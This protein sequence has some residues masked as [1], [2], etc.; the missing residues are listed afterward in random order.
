MRI[1]TKAIT[2]TKSA[3]SRVF[4]SNHEVVK[5]G[6]DGRMIINVPFTQAVKLHSIKIV[7]SGDEAPKTIRTYVNRPHTLSF[8]EADSIEG[9]E[10]ITLTEKDYEPNAITPLRFV[11]YQ[12]VQSLTV[13]LRRRWMIESLR[14]SGT[15]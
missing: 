2:K 6:D 14:F 13:C 5:S 7:A 9:V 3:V 15:K 1:V 12:S 8:D 4:T 11:K 10:T